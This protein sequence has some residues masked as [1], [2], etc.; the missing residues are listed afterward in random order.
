MKTISLNMKDE[1]S[2]LQGGKLEGMITDYP[3]DGELDKDWARPA[4]LVVP[5]GGYGMTSRREGEPIASAFMGQG[6]QVFVLYHSA[7]KKKLI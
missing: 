2:F 1:Y 6:F 3:Y 4:L 7:F 5:G